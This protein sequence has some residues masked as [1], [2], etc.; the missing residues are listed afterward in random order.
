MDAGA[1]VG[2]PQEVKEDLVK[3]NLLLLSAVVVVWRKEVMRKYVLH[4]F[5]YAGLRKG[6]D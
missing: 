6:V 3:W 1:T 4:P 2:A 5:D